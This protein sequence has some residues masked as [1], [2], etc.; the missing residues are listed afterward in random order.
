MSNISERIKREGRNGTITR[1]CDNTYSYSV[2][3][4]DTNE[5]MNWVK[6]YIGR[7]ISIEGSNKQVIKKFYRDIYRM[8]RLYSKD[9]KEVNP[10]TKTKEENPPYKAKED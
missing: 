5:M 2:Q 9:T 7:I 10:P 1:I 8:K 3:V 4:F 6:T